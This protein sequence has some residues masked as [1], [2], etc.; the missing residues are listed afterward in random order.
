MAGFGLDL[1]FVPVPGCFMCASNNKLAFAPVTADGAMGFVIPGSVM[2]N[3]G[4]AEAPNIKFL[5]LPYTALFIALSHLLVDPSNG[6]GLTTP[7]NWPQTQRLLLPLVPDLNPGDPYSIHYQVG[8]KA[9][10]RPQGFKPEVA[11]PHY[12]EWVVYGRGLLAE[13]A[14]TDTLGHAT[15]VHN[16][17]IA[18]GSL[19]RGGNLAMLDVWTEFEHVPDVVEAVR[20]YH[21][22][23]L[24]LA[25]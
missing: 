9:G 4:T 10:A 5:P 12:F 21:R 7:D 3:I 24:A 19:P 16:A 23:L 13:D 1:G 20:G 15:Q 8:T 18:A 25:A 11:P 6:Y 22:R 2:I 17:R 14:L